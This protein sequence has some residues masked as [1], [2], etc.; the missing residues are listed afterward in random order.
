MYKQIGT[1]LLALIFAV[2]CE[3]KKEYSDSELEFYANVLT[4]LYL[5][6]GYDNAKLRESGDTLLLDKFDTDTIYSLYGTTESDFKLK[7]DE[8]KKDPEAFKA[9]YAIINTRLDSLQQ[10]LK[11]QSKLSYSLPLPKNLILPSSADS[12]SS[13]SDKQE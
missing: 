4:Q 3:Q 12:T 1:V 7:Y 9:A 10:D 8:L 11:R 5:V 6:Q 2:S 13:G